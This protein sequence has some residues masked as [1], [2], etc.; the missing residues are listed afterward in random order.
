MTGRVDAQV[1]LV[2]DGHE[3]TAPAD[4]NYHER[5][6]DDRSLPRE[7]ESEGALEDHLIEQ[8]AAQ[9][10]A[11]VCYSPDPVEAL[12]AVDGDLK[13]GNR[14]AEAGQWDGAL[15]A[16]KRPQLKGDKEASRV[17]NL[18]VGHEALAYR[19]VTE[20]SSAP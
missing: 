6:K 11:A 8:A 3:R 7:V 2:R 18:G 15:A 10:V 1:E 14:L 13:P 20:L 16:W 19:L 4:A 12:L 5:F 9:A 17:H